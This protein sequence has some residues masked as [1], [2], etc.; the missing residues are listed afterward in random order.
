MLTLQTTRR[1][2]LMAS[3][4]ATTGMLLGGGFTKL[5]QAAIPPVSIKPQKKALVFIMLDGG[6]DS[7]NMLVPNEGT[8]YRQYKETRSN[9]AHDQRSLLDISGPKDKLGRS[10]GLHES[11]PEVRDLFEKKKLAFI[12]N[13]G[14]LIKPTNKIEIKEG[15][16]QLPLGLLS[17]ADQFKHWQTSRPDTRQNEGWLGY[18]ADALQPTRGDSQIPMNIS[19]AGHNTSQNG[20]QNPAYSITEEGSVGLL[21]NEQSDEFDEHLLNSVKELLATGYPDDPFKETYQSLTREA[22]NLHG[23]F[24]DATSNINI[25]TDFSNTPLSLQL[26]KVA[27]TIKASERMNLNQ[28]TYFLR[29]IGWDHHDELLNNQ[30]MMLRVLSKALGEFQFALEEMGLSDQ[31]VTFTGSDFGRTLTSNGNGTDHGWGGNSIVLG[32]PIDGGKFFGDYP[33]LG[34]GNDN[35]LDMGDGV[36]IPTTST[37]QLYADLS[38]WFGASYQDLETLFPNL[39][40]FHDLE[41][42]LPP[43]GLIRS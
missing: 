36:L 33:T 42:K 27:Q 2:F 1:D 16:A 12:N 20:T 41:S 22:Q 40:N 39:S 3:S 28:Q 23:N 18:F 35:P 43:L 24:Y 5:A 7:Y 19:M 6:N 14:P 15:S 11:M 37:D 30:H 38:L 9:L 10:F 25:A 34:L 31:V 8:Y 4:L 26:K 13:I 29:Y 21:I 17:H 32:D